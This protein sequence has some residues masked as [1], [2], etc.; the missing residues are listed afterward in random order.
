[1]LNE[2]VVEYIVARKTEQDFALMYKIYDFCETNFGKSRYYENWALNFADDT[3]DWARFSFYNA[4]YAVFAKMTFPDLLLTEEQWQDLQ[5][6]DV[7][8]AY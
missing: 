2:K 7:I 1:M 4:E 5:F 8:K 6:V 3:D